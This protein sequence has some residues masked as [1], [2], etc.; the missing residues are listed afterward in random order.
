MRAPRARRAAAPFA[1]AVLV[2][3]GA[4]MAATLPHPAEAQVAIRGEVVHPVSGPSIPDGVVLVGA[5][6]KIEAVGPASRVQVPA[7]YRTL[8]GAVVTPG[9]VD[10]HSVV[11]L[12]GYLNQPH[13]QDQMD[14]SSAIQ[15]ELRAIDAYNAREVLVEWLRSHGVTTVHTGHAPG[16]LV[17]GQTMIVKT[18]GENVSEAVLEPVTMV[19]VTIGAEAAQIAPGSPG[20]R[21]SAVAMLRQELV[22]AREYAER[23]AGS[24]PPARNL[25]METLA[26][27]L[28]G[29][30]RVLATAHR[31]MDIMTALRLREEFGLDMVLDGAAEAHLLVN[32]IRAAGVPVILHPPL[33]RY[34]GTLEHAT[35]ES[36]RI[37]KDAGIPVTIQSGYEPYVPKTRVVLFE[38]APLLG[39]GLS[40]DETL[41]L[42]TLDAARILRIDDRVGSLEVG[43][44]GDVAIFDGDPFEY[45]SRVCGVVIEG[46]VVSETCR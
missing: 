24:D 42:V 29:E 6:G 43:K 40:F 4:L 35:Y 31:T 30:I 25:R 7:G 28:A 33:A 39:H 3:M 26:A 45:V 12:A 41:E 8:S 11:G 46:E 37:L 44:D 13:D 21:P 5:D 9:L 22:R 23:R 38:A 2:A 27:V 19:A 15:P 14:L 10:A 17:S 1:A 36:A 32:E 16:P 20:S 34:A 18:R